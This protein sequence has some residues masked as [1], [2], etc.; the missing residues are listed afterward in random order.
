MALLLAGAYTATTGAGYAC[1]EWPLCSGYY[2]PGTGSIYVDTQLVHRW[3]AMISAITIGYLIYQ[4][5][6]WRADSP[7]MK[8]L[9][10]TLGGLMLLQIIG[11]AANIW[12]QMNTLFAALHVALATLVWGVLVLTVAV[13]NILPKPATAT[14]QA[15][16]FQQPEATASSEF[17]D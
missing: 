13:D 1:P 8:N 6:R 14:V 12:T 16:T 5:F 7:L 17:G 4:A 10:L 2:I 15:H 3:L 9:A 11:G